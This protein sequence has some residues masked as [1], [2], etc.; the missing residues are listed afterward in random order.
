MEAGS[1]HD[2]PATT[3]Q[4]ESVRSILTGV[5]FGLLL[6]VACLLVDPL[7]FKAHPTEPV[8]FHVDPLYPHLWAAAWAFVLLEG[9]ALVLH[10]LWRP[11][12]RGD[13]A[14]FAG[15][16]L[17]GALGACGIGVRLLPYTIPGIF[18]GVGVLG[19]V[20]FA[21]CVVYL[22][23]AVRAL[24]RSEVW[25]VRSL[26]VV[27]LLGM[28]LAVGTPAMVWK[29]GRMISGST[30]HELEVGRAGGVEMG[31]QRLRRYRFLV[32]MDDLVIRYDLSGDPEERRRLGRV[33]AAVMGRSIDARSEERRMLMD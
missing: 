2:E 14:L 6:P 30:L 12:R 10:M 32:Y 15:V 17:V 7:V 23:R 28:A 21:T 18:V 16:F 31:I 3:R 5:T 26:E 4:T 19:L 11:V 29:A 25:T 9:T 13:Q 27:L 33:Y 24:R 8:L 22:R 20:P 1:K